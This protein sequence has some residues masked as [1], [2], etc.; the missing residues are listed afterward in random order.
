[1]TSATT[2][3]ILDY[4]TAVG[5]VSTPVLVL[6]LTAVGWRIR[7]RIERGIELQDK[8]RAERVAVYNQVLEP[9]FILF[10]TDEIFAQDKRYKNKDKHQLAITKMLSVDYRMNAFQFALIG[11]DGAVRAYNDVFQFFYGRDEDDT[12]DE[13]QIK[14]MLKLLGTFLL[15]IRKS[16][17]NEVKQ[18]SNWEMLEWFITDARTYR[19]AK[20]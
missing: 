12:F 4:L 5:T 9:F 18:L 13:A 15:E 8:L 7:R 11:S 14:I 3:E 16:M 2:P 20:K 10:T 1:M 19:F 6:I 17:G